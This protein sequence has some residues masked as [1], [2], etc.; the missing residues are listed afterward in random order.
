MDGRPLEGARQPQSDMVSQPVLQIR[1]T[2]ASGPRA[3]CRCTVRGRQD[4]LVIRFFLVIHFQRCAK[5][6]GRFKN[7]ADYSS[8]TRKTEIR[9]EHWQRDGS[10]IPLPPVIEQLAIHTY[11][12]AEQNCGRSARDIRKKNAVLA[13]TCAKR[14]EPAARA[15]Y[16]HLASARSSSDRQPYFLALEVF[17]CAMFQSNDSLDLKSLEHCECVSN[18]RTRN[19]RTSS[20]LNAGLPTLLFLLSLRCCSTEVEEVPV[21]GCG[22]GSLARVP[23]SSDLLRCSSVALSLPGDFFLFADRALVSAHTPSFLLSHVLAIFLLLFFFER[24]LGF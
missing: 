21:R 23:H 14:S 11:V 7:V 13:N 19:S 1:Y 24:V 12:T 9:I 6:T 3:A 16:V 8:T 15:F 17:D 10:G 2:H 4:R 20:P 22:C 18:C 5:M